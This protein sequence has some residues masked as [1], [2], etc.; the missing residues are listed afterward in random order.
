[1]TANTPACVDEEGSASNDVG[2][3]A[4]PHGFR[5]YL[6]IEA[7]IP[8]ESEYTAPTRTETY[9]YTTV[10]TATG[11]PDASACG[12]I[13][14]TSKTNTY[15][16]VCARSRTNAGS[17]L[18][19]LR[20]QRKV[21]ATAGRHV[22]AC[23]V[24][25]K[26]QLSSDKTVAV[27]SRSTFSYYQDN[28]G[29]ADHGRL[30][31]Q[32]SR[33]LDQFPI[34]QTWQYEALDDG[35]RLAN[36]TNITTWGDLSIQEKTV[37]C[38]ITGRTLQHTNKAGV[39]EQF[40]Y[41]M[42]EQIWKTTTS[43]NTDFETVRVHEYAVLGEGLGTE[44][45]VTDANG[46]KTRYTR[47]YNAQ[48]Q[49]SEVTTIDWLTTDGD[50]P[51]TCEMQQRLEFDDWGQHCKTTDNSGRVT[52]S[53]TD[54]IDQC[55]TIGVEGEG[56]MTTWHNLAGLPTRTLFRKADGTDY[57]AKVSSYDGLYRLVREQDPLGR[58]TEYASDSFDRITDTTWLPG[59]RTT[60][61][62]NTDQSSTELPCKVVLNRQSVV[63]EQRFDGLGRMKVRSVGPR[64]TS[65]N[66]NGNTPEPSEISD[67]QGDVVYMEYEPALHYAPKTVTWKE[68]T[69]TIVYDPKVGKP[70]ELGGTYCT[71]TQTYD[72]VSYPWK[73]TFEIYDGSMENDECGRLSVQNQGDS[74]VA[75]TYDTASRLAVYQIQDQKAE[76]MVSSELTYDDFGRETA[77]TVKRG[78]EVLLTI[79]QE[80]NTLGLIESRSMQDGQASIL[81]S[82]GF[83]YDDYNHL[84][85]YEC[86]GPQAPAD[87]Q[88]R[89]LQSQSFTF[90][91][92]DNITNKTT[93]CQGDQGQ[94]V[95][96][97]QYS[98]WTNGL[99]VPGS[100]SV[101]MFEVRLK[102]EVLVEN[103]SNE[104][105][106]RA[107]PKGGG[108]APQAPPW[109]V[110]VN[111]RELR[112]LL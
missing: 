46:V 7:R 57:S 95:T 77:R 14:R 59:G 49:F 27:L 31:T 26:Q 3:P 11:A 10:P 63:G 56:T 93:V 85:Y 96:T 110:E 108:S 62:T 40:D 112:W 83:E 54:P 68:S 71:V 97:Y 22:T 111:E 1:M 48:G 109:E 100:R 34:I 16:V 50:N 76:L 81:R 2:C 84:M 58:V 94:N 47:N 64:V 20:C 28:P 29:A 61:T 6:K 79:I 17:A 32:E 66:Y 24:T 23:F 88:G 53:I 86:S 69:D 9:R 90:D 92:F 33:H 37:Y 19:S 12:I 102:G 38:S 107:V 43:P 36:I 103:D 4:D 89:L 99:G 106:C 72:A 73:E 82:E 74:E 35:S 105:G 70:A 5:R 13:G 52:I 65:Q 101:D 104:L 60:T 87:E 55:T 41:N 25:A 18:P 44:V 30:K 45:S 39:E 21:N 78:E 15:I 98:L 67:S 80:F 91:D 8:A 75:F 51:A 42:L